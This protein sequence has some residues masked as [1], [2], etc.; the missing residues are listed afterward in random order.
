M[1]LSKALEATFQSARYLLTKPSIDFTHSDPAQSILK[2]YALRLGATF[3]T[4][5]LWAAVTFSTEI[6]TASVVVLLGVAIGSVHLFL[7]EAPRR[8]YLLNSL[9]CTMIGI[10]V[11]NVLAGLAFFSSKMGIS[12]WQVLSTNLVPEKWHLL[13]SILIRSVHAVDF[14]YYLGALAAVLFFY[15][16]HEHRQ[17]L[18]KR[19]KADMR[20][21]FGPVNQFQFSG[22]CLNLSS[23]GLFLKTE[24]PLET[25]ENFLLR[26]TLPGQKSELSC[27][28]KVTWVNKK[29]YRKKHLCPPGGGLQFLGLPVENMKALLEFIRQNKMEPVC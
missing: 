4:A 9:L 27:K 6:F 2:L 24:I 29:E 3:A 1:P 19:F 22:D 12:Y 5:T 7:R 10:L 20:V 26:F 21:H 23:G 15:Y 18:G 11:C 28:A 25:G 16:Q 13:G 8:F 17:S 14:I